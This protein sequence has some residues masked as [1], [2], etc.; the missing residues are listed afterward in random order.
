[1]GALF[2]LFRSLSSITGHKMEDFL[3]SK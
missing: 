2:Y 3:R 1:M